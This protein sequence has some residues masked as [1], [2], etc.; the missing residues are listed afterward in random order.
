MTGEARGADRLGEGHQ[1]R[2]LGLDGGGQPERRPVELAVQHVTGVERV[3]GLVCEGDEL[4]LAAVGVAEE[5]EQRLG[6][7][8]TDELG[9]QEDAL[10]VLAR[11]LT[12]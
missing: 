10:T 7:P 3:E 4:R 9:G 1:A 5:V 12:R 2:V 8:L 6:D 11:H